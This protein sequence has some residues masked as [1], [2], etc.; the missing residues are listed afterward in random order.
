M[1]SYAHYDTTLRS[2]VAEVQAGECIIAGTR[3]I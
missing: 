2:N 1:T 3:R